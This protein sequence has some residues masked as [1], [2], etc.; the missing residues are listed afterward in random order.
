MSLSDPEQKPRITFVI[1]QLGIIN[2][3]STNPIIAKWWVILKNTNWSDAGQV[4]T[5]RQWLDKFI[6]CIDQNNSPSMLLFQ[7]TALRNE[8]STRPPFIESI[9]TDLL[10]HHY[11]EDLPFVAMRSFL[12]LLR[13]T[14]DQSAEPD[15]SA[16]T[17]INWA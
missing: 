13:K 15:T 10:A 3:D 9:V 5:T 1:D 12:D 16:S 6:E 14:I 4:T 8:T 7:I 2:V 17:T 11:N